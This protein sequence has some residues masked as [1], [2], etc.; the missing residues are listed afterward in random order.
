M[1]EVLM[2]GTTRRIKIVLKLPLYPPRYIALVECPPNCQS[3]SPEDT[4][5]KVK[6]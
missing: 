6:T 5:T 2:Q 1:K 4:S 3:S